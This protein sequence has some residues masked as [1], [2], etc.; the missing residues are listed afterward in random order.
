MS[1]FQISKKLLKHLYHKDNLST[2]EIGKRFGV[3]ATTIQT[4]LKELDIPVKSTS[5]RQV[6]RHGPIRDKDK[7]TSHDTQILIKLKDADFSVSD[8][9]TIM[10]R[11]RSM[12]KRVMTQM[13]SK[14]AKKK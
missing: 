1:N 7:W 3:S 12:I 2:Y 9:S 6:G 11:S 10:A 14:Y 13:E 5:D 4:K 8:I